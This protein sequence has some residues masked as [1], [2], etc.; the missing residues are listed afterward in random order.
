MEVV[1]VIS[2]FAGIGILPINT[3]ERWRVTGEQ[4][5]GWW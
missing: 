2:Q 5:T 3:G 1:I 4:G